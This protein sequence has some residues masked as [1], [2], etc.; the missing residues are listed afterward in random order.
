MFFEKN[1]SILEVNGFKKY[2]I[3]KPSF[4]IRTGI[5]EI[6]FRNLMKLGYNVKE[7]YSGEWIKMT[8]NEKNIFLN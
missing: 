2:S 7:L 3:I 4:K 5:Y 1:N 6:K 8:N